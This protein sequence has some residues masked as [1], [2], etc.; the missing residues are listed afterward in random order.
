[1][2]L[3]HLAKQHESAIEAALVTSG[4][5]AALDEYRNAQSRLRSVIHSLC[6][7][8]AKTPTGVALKVRATA[9]YAS[10]GS[11]ERFTATQLLARAVWEDMGED[12]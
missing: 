10:F 12:A 3:Y 2:L 7:I 4:L 5:S 1:M 6:E 9:A 11:E 8:R